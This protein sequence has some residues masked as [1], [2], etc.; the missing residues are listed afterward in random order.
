V[1]E[2]VYMGYALSY[3]LEGAEVPLHVTL[4]RGGLRGAQDFAPGD[5]V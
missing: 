5:A 3:R 2:R 4:P 1:A